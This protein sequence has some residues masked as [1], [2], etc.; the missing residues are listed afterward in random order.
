MDTSANIR[1]NGTERVSASNGSLDNF[2]Y[3]GLCGAPWTAI[4]YNDFGV[5]EKAFWCEG[6]LSAGEITTLENWL[7]VAGDA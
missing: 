3:V 6:A 7:A 1:L 2:T 5:I 4:N